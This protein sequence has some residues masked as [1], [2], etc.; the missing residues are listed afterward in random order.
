M[1]AG[2]VRMEGDGM[3]RVEGGGKG[4]SGV[5]RKLEAG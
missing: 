5:Y 1:E 4:G 2:L 3:V